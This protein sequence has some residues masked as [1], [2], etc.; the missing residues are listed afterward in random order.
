MNKPIII[1][2]LTNNTKIYIK[3]D[4]EYFC[5]YQHDTYRVIYACDNKLRVFTDIYWRTRYTFED[6]TDHCSMSSPLFI[7][8]MTC[9]ET[10]P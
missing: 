4:D 9:T 5:V 1:K 3:V 2:R 10:W 7:Y 8:A 6:H